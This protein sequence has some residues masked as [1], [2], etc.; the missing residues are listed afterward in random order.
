MIDVMQLRGFLARTQ[1]GYL[2][3][4]RGIARHYHWGLDEPFE[5]YLCANTSSSAYEVPIPIGTALA[6]IMR[7]ISLWYRW[8]DALA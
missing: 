2:N 5:E 7:M 3:A 8:L 1:D 4:A 6:R